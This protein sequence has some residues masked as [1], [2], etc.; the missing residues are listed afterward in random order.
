MCLNIV[1]LT[2]L[3]A[4]SLIN[5]G[6]TLRSSML[7]A[8]TAAVRDR[9]MRTMAAVN[10]PAVIAAHERVVDFG[11]ATT[12]TVQRMLLHSII[13]SHILAAS[14]PIIGDV[15]LHVSI[16]STVADV[17]P[18]ANAPSTDGTPE[19]PTWADVA[20]R[21]ASASTGA[22]VTARHVFPP[23]V[24]LPRDRPIPVPTAQVREAEAID[25]AARTYPEAQRS[26]QRVQ[27]HDVK[28]RKFD[29]VSSSRNSASDVVDF[30]D[31]DDD[32]SDDESD[33]ENDDADVRDTRKRKQQPRNSSAIRS[34]PRKQRARQ[35]LLSAARGN[36]YQS[37]ALPSVPPPPS[38][39]ADHVNVPLRANNTAP[40]AAVTRD[41]VSVIS[42]GTRA[43]ALDNVLRIAD[44]PRLAV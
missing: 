9:P 14:I 13:M 41:H 2:S 16:P 29:D 34:G 5:G 33:G 19:E 25:S 38:V 28:R 22:P 43:A 23:P 27:H 10:A 1:C 8:T 31:D 35:R 40:V 6:V 32:E 4:P 20:M 7:S 18:T 17:V 11:A 26:W 30:G 24:P 42:I 44:V 12:H 21:P 15:P 36:R 39:H 3:T 37:S